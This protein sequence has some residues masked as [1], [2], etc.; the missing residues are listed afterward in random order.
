MKYIF[1]IFFNYVIIYEI[2]ST[3]SFIMSNYI[4]ELK[5]YISNVLIS[6]NIKVLK[7]LFGAAFL[8]LSVVF[9]LLLLTEGV[10]VDDI[11]FYVA[12]VLTS[13]I[14]GGAVLP[15]FINDDDRGIRIGIGIVKA[16]VGAFLCWMLAFLMIVS[17]HQMVA[18]IIGNQ[19]ALALFSDVYFPIFIIQYCFMSSFFFIFATFLMLLF[20]RVIYSKLEN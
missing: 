5:N 17:F 9:L 16:L 12:L 18:A 13:F 7:H 10:T 11:P 20:W 14:L 1:I 15:Y 4:C 8:S 6:T 19:R 3:I 2:L